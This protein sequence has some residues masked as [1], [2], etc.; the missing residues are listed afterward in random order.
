MYTHLYDIV[1]KSRYLH[2]PR[3][4]HRTSVKHLPN[5]YLVFLFPGMLPMCAEYSSYKAL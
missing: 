5:D 2:E 3:L 4:I 1:N